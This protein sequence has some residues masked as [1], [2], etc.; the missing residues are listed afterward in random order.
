MGFRTLAAVAAVAAGLSLPAGAAATSVSYI[1]AG[2]DVWMAS[3]DGAAAHRLTTG[4]G[5]THVAQSDNGRTVAVSSTTRALAVWNADGARAVTGELPQSQGGWSAVTA[6]VGLDISGDGALIAYSYI[7]TNLDPI[8]STR[9][10]HYIIA[11]DTPEPTILHDA[12]GMRWPT[13]VGRRTVAS[14]ADG[15]YVQAGEGAPLT[16]DFSAWLPEPSGSDYRPLDTDVAS[17]G[18]LAV[19]RREAY[20]PDRLWH[21]GATRALQIAGLGAAPTA[22]CALPTHGDASRVS[23]SPDGRHIAW[24]DDRGV[25]VA[26]APDFA[27]CAPAS[28]PVMIAAAATYPSIG[29]ATISGSGPGSAPAPGPA[30]GAGPTRPGGDAVPAKLAVAVPKRLSRAALRRGYAVRVTTPRAGRV[31]LRATVPGARL[32]R[33]GAA[34]RRAVAVA[35]GV[36]RAHGA[37]TLTIKLRFTAAG[38]RASARLKGAT[39]TVRATVGASAATARVR[40]R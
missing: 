14:I 29:G 26:G 36:T 8:A 5:W 25:V 18:T 1:D 6:P 33:K 3:L 37:G 13:F 4:G 39:L 11:A 24:A 15:V 30:P 9:Q 12:S 31:A 2:G 35:A 32:G 16:D 34:A 22:E 20:T 7:N 19:V 23:V 38:R 28:P 17:N 21:Q 40:L 27:T 10:G